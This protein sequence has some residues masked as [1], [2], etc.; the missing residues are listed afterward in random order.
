MK[1]LENESKKDK[2]S[3]IINE[4]IIPKLKLICGELPPECAELIISRAKL[5]TVVKDQCFQEEGSYEDGQLHYLYSGIACSCYECPGT[6]KLGI[7]RIWKKNEVLFD[8]VSFLKNTQRIESFQMLED[9]EILSLDYYS[10]KIIF[11]RFPNIYGTLLFLL[12]DLE[13]HHKFYE[14]LLKLTVEERV[15]QYLDK[16]PTLM[17]RINREC[18]ALYLDISKGRLSTAYALYKQQKQN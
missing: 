4:E 16:N 8:T 11:D 9:G 6:N 12:A 17:S 15:K 3:R 10:L 5:K 2:L 1:K 13:A 14:Q 18:I 7:C